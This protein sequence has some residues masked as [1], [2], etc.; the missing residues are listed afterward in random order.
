M[1]IN[2]WQHICSKCL[3]LVTHTPTRYCPRFFDQ[4]GHQTIHASIGN[5]H[6][7]TLSCNHQTYQNYEQSR[8]K[9]D[10]FLENK[11]LYLL[12]KCPILSDLF[13]ILVTLTMTLFS[14]KVVISNRCIRGLMPNLI[15][16]SWTVS[17]PYTQIV[18]NTPQ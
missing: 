1:I 2:I 8:Q 5:R 7:F 9:L 12:E 14:E 11:V 18:V 17:S 4:V 6:F 15:K 3:N 10:T 13:I 16:K